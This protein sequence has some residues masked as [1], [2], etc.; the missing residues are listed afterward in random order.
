MVRDISFTWVAQPSNISLSKSHMVSHILV[1]A[2]LSMYPSQDRE[3]QGYLEEDS[4][5]FF[6]K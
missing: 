4:F 1:M 3:D 5:S 2:K 6:V